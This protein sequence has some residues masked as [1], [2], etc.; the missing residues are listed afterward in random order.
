MPGTKPTNPDP[1]PPARRKADPKVIALI[2]LI[3][4]VML[5]VWVWRNPPA[6]SA[7]TATP[8]ASPTQT[9]APVK[10]SFGPQVVP[11]SRIRE[12]PD[13]LGHPVYWAGQIDGRDFE[14]TMADNGAVGLRYLLAGNDSKDQDALTVATQPNKDAYEQALAAHPELDPDSAT[15]AGSEASPDSS[16]VRAKRLPDGSLIFLDPAA[17][18][19][20]HLVRED[21]P[22]LISVYAPLGQTWPMLESGQITPIPAQG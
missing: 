9:V 19:V 5:G 7:G 22:Y 15:S 6:D 17:T 10:N 21:L 11:Q 4:G 16:L 14:L 20:G 13:E 12:L 8:S 2:S 1:K 3:T 18:T